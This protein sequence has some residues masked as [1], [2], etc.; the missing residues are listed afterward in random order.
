MGLRINKSETV[1][2]GTAWLALIFTLVGSFAATGTFVGGMIGGSAHHL[3]IY[4]VLPVAVV[5]GGMFFYDIVD[6]GIPNRIRT[7]A[8]AALW[9][10]FL[11]G[12]Q[13]KGAKNVNGWIHDMNNNLDDKVG[14]WVSDNP[15]HTTTHILMATIAL[16]CLGFGLYT[17]FRYFRGQR[18]GRRAAATATS[19][20]TNTPIIAA[21]GNNRKKR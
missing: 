8:I 9:P 10:S 11:L 15:D 20:G 18:A 16:S 5:T 14:P 17:A 19:T 2:D 6:D 21:G 4:I 1:S 13:G 12:A 3:P 7:F